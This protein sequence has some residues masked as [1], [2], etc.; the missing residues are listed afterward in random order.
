MAE[1]TVNNNFDNVCI[2][3]WINAKP[4]IYDNLHNVT[5]RAA[6]Y[7]WHHSCYMVVPSIILRTSA[8]LCPISTELNPDYPVAQSRKQQLIFFLL[9]RPIVLHDDGRKTWHE[10]HL[11]IQCRATVLRDIRLVSTSSVVCALRFVA[12][13]TAEWSVEATD[14]SSND[15][16]SKKSPRSRV[17]TSKTFHRYR[18]YKKD[19]RYHVLF[20]KTSWSTG[21]VSPSTQSTDRRSKTKCARSRTK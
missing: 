17:H 12:V 10:T 20:F 3:N 9:H 16:R 5:N 13:L 14:Q 6:R 4:H 1:V 18:H 15:G 8:Y 21:A 19:H 11:P 7:S 2:K